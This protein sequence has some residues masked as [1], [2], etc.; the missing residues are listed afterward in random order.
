M[1][2]TSSNKWQNSQQLARIRSIDP[3]ARGT[4]IRI[5]PEEETTEKKTINELTQTEWEK[6]TNGSYKREISQ[7]N[8]SLLLVFICG[9]L[10]RITSH[11]SWGGVQCCSFELDGILA[12]C[13]VSSW[14][15]AG[16]IDEASFCSLPT[17]LS[18]LK[19]KVCSCMWSSRSTPWLNYSWSALL[20][21]SGHVQHSAQKKRLLHRATWAQFW[22]SQLQ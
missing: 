5:D 18:Q 20:V 14:V 22:I 2:P 16:A 6:S 10:V 9:F 7:V 8:Y 3:K 13:C 12:D 15:I 21:P 11:T 19:V 17:Q 1:P 4:C